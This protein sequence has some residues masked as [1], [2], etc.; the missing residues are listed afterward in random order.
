MK[1]KIFKYFKSKLI[2]GKYSI[3]YLIAKGNFGEVYFGTN[4]LNGKNYALKIEETNKDDLNLKQECFV[5]TYLK[6]PYVPSVITFGISGKYSILVENLLGKSMKEIWLEKKKKLNLN[7]TCTFAIQALSCLEYIHSK[8]YIHRDIKPANF[9]VGNPD[10]SQL[11]LIDFGNARKYRSTR[12]GKHIKLFKSNLIYGS[13]IFLSFNTLKGMEQTR[14]DD[15]ESLGYV[16]IY[17]Y[18]GSLSWNN[19]KYKDVIQ[20]IIKTK[21]IRE[22]LSTENICKG[23]PEEMINYMNYV[24]NLKYDEKPDYE[25]LRSLFMNILKKIGVNEPLFSWADRNISPIRRTI[26]YKRNKSIKSI[27]NN[28]L[29]KNSNND[30]SSTNL[31]LNLNNNEKQLNN[32]KNRNGIIKTNNYISNTQLNS[33][34]EDRNKI[35]INKNNIIDIKKI[36]NQKLKKITIYKKKPKL[37][38]GNV[39]PQNIVALNEGNENN[40]RKFRDDKNSN[41]YNDKLYN[42]DKDISIST[43]NNIT[44]KDNYLPR[45][46]RKNNFININNSSF[47]NNIFYTHISLLA[48]YN[49]SKLNSN[50]NR[51]KINPINNLTCNSIRNISSNSKGFND[52]SYKPYPYRSIF[53]KEI[54]SP[55]NNIT[56]YASKINKF[57]L[58]PIEEEKINQFTYSIFK[59]PIKFSEEG[60]FL[61][62]KKNI[63]RPKY[64]QSKFLT[65]HASSQN[66]MNTKLLTSYY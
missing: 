49:N 54:P 6:G 19:L 23:M 40:S 14:R 31:K 46:N 7:D 64:Y 8:D 4:E 24:K 47:N 63:R 32:Y 30:C 56:E 28:L 33:E 3:K 12:T 50:N 22:K 55:F 57:K 52:L 53:S 1:S 59:N 9:L 58:N 41:N 13:L 48:N 37:I 45:S 5:L 15:L 27:Y 60:S 29:K 17:L 51:I 43:I 66:I 36:S 35:N 38:L 18:I 44:K 10:T 42:K 25:Y 61:V 21:K 11:Y 65:E 34:K 20:G 62:N 16:I 39:N 2:F 26:S